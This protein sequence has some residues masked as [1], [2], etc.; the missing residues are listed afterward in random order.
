MRR[1]PPLQRQRHWLVVGLR[2][3]VLAVTLVG[4]LVSASGH[5][6][7]HGLAAMATADHPDGG[8]HGHE[9]HPHHDSAD[10]SHDKAHALPSRSGLPP[11]APADWFLPFGAASAGW[12][13]FPLDRPPRS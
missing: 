11:Q 1:Q 9:S 2:L 3:W 7:S 10:H 8:S 4:T 12:V 5:V 13:N 6:Q